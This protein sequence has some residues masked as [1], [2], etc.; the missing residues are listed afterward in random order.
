MAGCGVWHLTD[1]SVG[2]FPVILVS[3]SPGQAQ[4]KLRDRQPAVAA[5]RQPGQ[6]GAVYVYLFIVYSR[7][8][9]G[10]EPRPPPGNGRA[11]AVT[12]LACILRPIRP[13]ASAINTT[14]RYSRAGQQPRWAEAAS[15]SETS[16]LWQPPRPAE[17]R[18]RPR[19]ARARSHGS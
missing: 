17:T 1:V 10:S 6:S 3:S 18:A 16:G 5:W 11:L 12:R 15:Y 9:L 8:E 4:D 13:L 14:K 19:L 7:P 2:K